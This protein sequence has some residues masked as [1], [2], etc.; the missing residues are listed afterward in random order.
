MHGVTSGLAFLHNHNIVDCDLKAANV[1]IGDDGE[2][3]YKVKLGDFGMARFDFEQFSVSILPSNNDVVMGTAAYTAPELLERGTK[4]SFQSD[5]YSLGMVMTEFSLPDRSTPW[6][7]E[8]ANSALIYDYIR[9]RERPAVTE[10]NLTGLSDD[11]ARQWMRLLRACWDQDP[12][13]RPSATDA[14]HA[15]MSICGPEPG[16]NYKTFE[17]LSDKNPD[18]LF[19][20]LSTHQGMA[21]ELMDEVVSSFTSQNKSISEDLKNDLASNFQASDGSNSCVYLCTKIAHELLKCEEVSAHKIASLIQNVAEE[22]IRSLPNRVNYLRKVS[23]YADVYDA[24]QIMNQH[25]IINTQ[26]TTTEILVKQSS[27]NLEDKQRHLKLALKSL[28]KSKNA[29]GKAFAV[30]TCNPYAILVGVV[31][32]NFIIINT[33]EVHEEVGGKDSGLWSSLI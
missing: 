15:M 12:S 13:R 24:L 9:R 6:E 20:P 32:S 11:N 8:L 25:A 26:Y 17:H 4:P 14:H 30:Y 2:G 1:F 16:N 22:T 19:V 33:H 31:R 23:D 29:E 10:E 27:D 3:K 18:T 28:E 7:G 21:V 5:M